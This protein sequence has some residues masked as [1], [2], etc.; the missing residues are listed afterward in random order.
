MSRRHAA[1]LRSWLLI[2]LFFRASVFMSFYLK[3]LPDLTVRMNLALVSLY[4]S[5]CSP[6]L[7]LFFVTTCSHP[8]I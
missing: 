7:L 6:T 8:L 5:F 3:R 2:V 1:R 4:H